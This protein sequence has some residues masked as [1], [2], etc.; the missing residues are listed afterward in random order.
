MRVMPLAGWL[1]A[2]GEDVEALLVAAVS[3]V[4]VLLAVEAA[5]PS[6]APTAPR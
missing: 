2:V 3:R 1:A 4:G 5:M 6:E